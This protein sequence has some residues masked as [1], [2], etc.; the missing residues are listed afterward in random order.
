MGLK[1]WLRSKLGMAEFEA[2]QTKRLK[3]WEY[4]QINDWD[5]LEA[6]PFKD[7]ARDAARLIETSPEAAF[8]RLLAL[9]KQ[10]SLYSMNFVA[11]C[12][13]VGTGATEDVDEAMAWYQRA[14]EGGSDRALLEFGAFLV[15]KGQTVEA[16][17]V[18]EAGWQRA[19]VPAVYRLIRMRLKPSLPLRTRLTWKPSLE[20]AAAAGHPAARHLLS[21]YLLRGWFGVLGIPRGV[22]LAYAH[23]T[24]VLRDDEDLPIVA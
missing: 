5:L 23:V 22:G 11:W 8:D 13:V 21:R 19:F 6:D 7:E 4:A 18:Y 16:E 24:G 15:W 20:W 1:S 14:Y 12:L 3:A 10:G 2:E 9:A 17:Q